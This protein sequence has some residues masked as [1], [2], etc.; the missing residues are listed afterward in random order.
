MNKNNKILVTG[1]DGF[2][3][4]HLVESL[5]EQNFKVTAFCHYN[6]FGSTGWIH[7]IPKS[8]KKKLTIILGDIRDHFFINDLIKKHEYIFHLASLISIPYSYNAFSSYVE[9]NINGTLNILNACRSNKIKRLLI[10]ST[11]EVYGSALYTPIDEGHPLQAQ[12]PYSATKIASDNLSIS[13][14][15]SFNVPLVV[16]RPF[17]AYG[18]RQSE[19]AVIPTIIS[20]MIKKNEIKL[21]SLDTI[22]DFN[23]VLDT[24]DGLIKLMSKKNIEGE[25]INISSGNGYKIKEIFS[26]LKKNINPRAYVKL[27]KKRVRPINSEVDKLIGCNKKIKKLT[28]WSSKISLDKGLKYTCKWYVENKK[29][30]NNDKNTYQI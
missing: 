21:G 29:F 15:K 25:I 9:T 14:F 1:A 3:G 23:Y 18:P 24:V 4:S 7:A 16:A 10:T 28:N 27:D 2:I 19:R 11:S 12:S 30:L 22:R 5:L 13:F 8:I 6:S 17:N 26:I 20:Q